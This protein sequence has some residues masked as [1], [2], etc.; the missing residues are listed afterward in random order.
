MI[1]IVF[2]GNP[3]VGKTALIN[4]ISGGD[5]K[6]GNWPGVTI[7]K[8]EVTFKLNNEDINLVDLPGVYGL[9]GSTPEEQITKDYLLNENIDVIINVVDSTSLEKNLYLTSILK[10]LNIPIVM[11]LNFDDEFKKVGYTLNKEKFEK[12]IGIKTIFTNGK[13]GNG[14]EEL[15][16]KAV[17]LYKNSEKNNELRNIDNEKVK[18]TYF[19][20]RKALSENLKRGNGDKF[21]FTDKVDKI[22]LNKYLGGLS[23]LAIIY[24]MFVIVFD[25]SSPYIDWVDGFFGDFVMKYV[26]HMIEGV[27]EWLYSLITDGIIAGVGSVLT[28]V[29]LM[30]FIYFFLAVLEESGYMARVAFILNKLMTKVGLSGKAFIPMLLGFG[31]TVPAIYSTRTLEDEKTRRLTGVIATFMSCGAR[32]PVYSLMAVAFFSE[33]AALIVV[34]VYLIG[35]VTA[36]LVAFVLKRFDYFKGDNTELLIELPPYRMPS[37]LV[38]WRSMINK[39]KMYVVNATTVILAI[40]LVIWALA[41]FPNNGDAET[42]YLGMSAKVVQP[43]FEPTGFGNKWQPVASVVPSIIAKETV[44]GFLGQMIVEAEE[45]EA[46]EEV[47]Y[48]FVADLTDQVIGLKDATLSSISSLINVVTFKVA[49][50]EMVDEEGLDEEAGGKVIP[51][52]RNLWDDEFGKLRAYSFMLYILMVVP[53]AV[54]MGALKQEFGW[55]L[56]AFQ[57]GM[58]LVLP[59]VISVLFF[60]VAKLFV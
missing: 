43:I 59:Y 51:A 25:G 28:F 27:P 10:E 9:L 60:N 55:K 40:L 32:L 11:A 54:S 31:C 7:E 35:I 8:K 34:S 26:G 18:R 39:T 3:N 15:L 29:P 14:I 45:G 5:L 33:N 58:L 44:V 38:V 13:N 37:F 20:Y 53:C 17:D 24:A 36:L 52:M 42:S 41:Y 21:A 46:E 16:N 2:V 6:V 57:T 47:E 30:L 4:K 22:L 56:L 50:L 23:F 49:T 19:E 12:E 1:N 48:N